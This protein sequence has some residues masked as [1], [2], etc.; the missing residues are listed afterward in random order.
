MIQQFK[1]SQIIET[2][3]RNVKSKKKKDK[4]TNNPENFQEK[5]I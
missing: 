4:D 3:L 1:N 2:L 5:K